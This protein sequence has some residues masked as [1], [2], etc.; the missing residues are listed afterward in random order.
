MGHREGTP[1]F[2]TL[3]W[4][5]WHSRG[6]PGPG[7]HPTTAACRQGGS[8]KPGKPE[9]TQKPAPLGLPQRRH[10][11]HTTPLSWL[12]IPAETRMGSLSRPLTA[13]LT[14]DRSHPTSSQCTPVPPG[15]LKILELSPAAHPAANLA[16]STPLGTFTQGWVL[17]NKD[18]Q[19]V[20]LGRRVKPSAPE[21]PER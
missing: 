2:Q 17:R 15:Q 8:S 12:S 16:P 20:S 4:Q 7:H 14:A 3:L 19:R 13:L 10:C 18:H 21:P 9:P 1:L 6:P 11:R 5:A